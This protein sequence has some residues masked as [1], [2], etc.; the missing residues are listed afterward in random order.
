MRAI[1][2][3][4]H[5]WAGLLTAGFLFFSG[6]TGAIISWDHEID[7]VLNSH[8]FDVSSKGPAIPSIDI[9]PR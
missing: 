4:L 6:V 8:L 5:R 1:F 3:K 2:G 7:E 9:S